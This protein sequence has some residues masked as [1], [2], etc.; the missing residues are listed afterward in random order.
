MKFS[1]SATPA[2]VQVVLAAAKHLQ[3]KAFA[4]VDRPASAVPH[5]SVGPA[6][7]AR[8]R[9]VVLRNAESAALRPLD[10]RLGREP[11]M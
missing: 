2:Q 10:K 5:A 9:A 4:L 11:A 8:P 3:R 1:V 7:P 6:R